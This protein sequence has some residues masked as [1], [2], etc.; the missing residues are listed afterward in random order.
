MKAQ[1]I[2]DSSG[3]KVAVVLPVKAFEKVMEDLEELDDIR[4]FDRAKRSAAKGVPMKDAF[5]QVEARRG[6]KA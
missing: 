3:K 4:L 1:F 6:K 2:T 5:S